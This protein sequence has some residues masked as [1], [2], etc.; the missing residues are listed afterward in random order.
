MLCLLTPLPAPPR[1]PR[2]RGRPPGEEPGREGPHA[3]VPSLST[4]NRLRVPQGSGD[5]PAPR[6]RLPC[7]AE[8]APAGSFWAL[9]ALPEPPSAGTPHTQP[10]LGPV[11]STRDPLHPSPS[12]FLIRGHPPWWFVNISIGPTPPRNWL[13]PLAT[14][15]DGGEVGGPGLCLG[16][17]GPCVYDPTCEYQPTPIKRFKP[18]WTVSC[19]A[20]QLSH[21]EEGGREG[22]LG[23]SQR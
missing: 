15:G 14:L 7:Q 20:W 3:P 18:T 2:P 4:G 5:P 1:A 21:P 17:S 11:K 22:A 19:W 13:K 12:P 23:G 10:C 9:E 6:G 8:L 16:V